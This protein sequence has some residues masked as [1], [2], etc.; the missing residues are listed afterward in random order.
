MPPVEFLAERKEAGQTIA[1]L[2]RKRFGLSWSQAKRLIE[3]G[4]VRVAGFAVADPGHRVRARNRIWIREGVVQPPPVSREAMPSAPSPPAP[5]RKP[6]KSP[7]RPLTPSPPLI[8]TPSLL[9]ADDAVV[10]ANKPAGLTTMR[11]A[12]EADEFGP[13]GQR[14]LPTTLADLLPR[15]L[16][17]PG[18][19]V[20]PV[21]RIDR[22]T[23]GGVVFART[24]AAAKH[25]TRQFRKHTADRRYLA[26]VRGAP[27]VGRIESL[28]VRDRGD[29]RRGSGP[30]PD[31]KRAV[32]HVKVLER[33]GSFALVECRLE[34]GR[35][36]QVRIHL[37]EAGAPL[38]G[39]RVYDRPVNGK[40]LPDGSGAERPM[41]HAARLGFVHPATGEPMSWEVPPPD[42]FARL[43]EKLRGPS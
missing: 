21:H 41:L 11:H 22:D 10:V 38:C 9:Y 4:H 3:R 40:P 36:H 14:F 24:P 31:G 42:D 37:G 15:L 43:L 35:T 30:G 2:L 20:I 34:S 18:A 8:R 13:R 19:R 29:G 16:G 17:A 28:L 39:E 6:A 32:T 23:S 25:L 27:P 26:L 33:L 5:K 12:A 1:A 7:P